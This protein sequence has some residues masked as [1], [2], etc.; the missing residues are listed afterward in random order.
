[1]M[2]TYLEHLLQLVL[3][4]SGAGLST[5]PAEMAKEARLNEH[6]VRQG[7]L[8]LTHLGL[9]DD[10]TWRLTMGGL[11]MAVGARARERDRM[12]RMAA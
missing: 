1:M 6:R 2:E 3:A 9:V 8:K 5:H 10:T 11:V 4:R 12:R 7:L